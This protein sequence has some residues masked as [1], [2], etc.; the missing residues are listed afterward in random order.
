MAKIRG[1]YPGGPRR[2]DEDEPSPPPVIE[3]GEAVEAR[4]QEGVRRHR[5]R[6][7]RRRILAALA[8]MAV[9]AAGAGLWLG[10]RSHRSAEEIAD[11]EQ[12]RKQEEQ[13]QQVLERERQRI[14]QELWRMEAQE[15]APRP[16]S[17]GTPR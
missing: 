1:P 3:S 15:R 7:K 12:R 9:L 8:G 10:L 17:R 16:P 13:A 11:Q 5:E 14:L 6:R 4:I 2:P